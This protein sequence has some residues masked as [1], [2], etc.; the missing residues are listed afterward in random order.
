MSEPVT[1]HPELVVLEALL[2]TCRQTCRLNPSFDVRK[3]ALDQEGKLETQK[4]RLLA[5]LSAEPQ[6]TA[7]VAA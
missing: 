6:A 4:A 1:P 5:R 7:E 2:E 3:A